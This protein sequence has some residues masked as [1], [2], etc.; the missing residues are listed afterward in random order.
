MGKQ[1]KSMEIKAKVLYNA[2]LPIV[3]RLGVY[4]RLIAVYGHMKFRIK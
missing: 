2:L 3:R 4:H 1:Q